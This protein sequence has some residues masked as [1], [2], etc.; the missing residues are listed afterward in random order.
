MSSYVTAASEAGDWFLERLAAYQEMW[1]KNITAINGYL[2]PA[3]PMA[4]ADYS[5]PAEVAK[6]NF[7]FMEKLLTQQKKFA[8]ALYNVAQPRQASP[9]RKK[10]TARPAASSKATTSKKTATRKTRTK[11][12]A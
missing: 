8:V 10:T 1:L 4:K 2:F 5:R 9:T 3:M 12:S 7:D 6:A 11:S